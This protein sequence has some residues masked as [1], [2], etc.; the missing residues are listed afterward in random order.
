MSDTTT[1]AAPLAEET[2]HQKS[3]ALLAVA[4]AAQILVTLVRLPARKPD[5]HPHP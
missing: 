4:L 2:G 1:P 5:W 3:W